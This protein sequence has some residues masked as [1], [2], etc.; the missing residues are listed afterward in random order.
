MAQIVGS[1]PEFTSDE[2]VAP[3]NEEV[4]VPPPQEAAPEAP[5]ELPATEPVVEAASA[6]SQTQLAIQA[7]ELEKVKLLKEISELRG[8]KRE[9]KQEQLA[10]VQEHIDDLKDVNP[11]D[12]TLIDRVLKQKGYMTK[13]EVDLTYRQS[14]QND[15]LAQFLERYP[16]YKPENDPGDQN[17]SRLQSELGFYKMPEDPH[18]I[19]LLLEKAHG[20][21]RKVI[22]SVPIA[23]KKRAIEVASHGSGGAQR[24]SGP[25]KTVTPAQRAMYERGGWSEDE[26]KSIESKLI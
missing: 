14:V 24:S 25:T 15:K 12:V 20:A 21:V 6:P 26:I 4:L 2:G 13:Q 1:I 17:W 5:A 10:K 3:A 9:L 23:L 8:N 22:P 19:A 18:Q 16:E 7:I 11:Q